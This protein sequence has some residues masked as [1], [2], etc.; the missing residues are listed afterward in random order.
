MHASLGRRVGGEP[1]HRAERHRRGDE[2]DARLAGVLEQR[3]GEA[4]H[5]DGAPEV[6]L[7]LFHGTRGGSLRRQRLAGHYARAVYQQVEATEL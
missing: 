3:Q 6:D 5:A 7:D 1:G 2:H 4:G